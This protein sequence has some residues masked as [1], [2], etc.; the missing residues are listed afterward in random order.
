MKPVRIVSLTLVTDE[1]V[2]GLVDAT[3]IVAMSRFAADESAS[4]V[5]ETAKRIGRVADRDVEQIVA[6]NP[7]LVLS[8]RYTK[9]NAREVLSRIGVPYHELTRFETVQ[10][11]AGNIR[12]I[13]K[14]LNES[15]RG[16]VL[17][18]EMHQKLAEAGKQLPPDRRTW[19]ALYLAPGEWTAGRRTTFDELIRHTGMRNAAAESGLSGNV[20]VS[21]EQIIRIN[22]DLII[23]GT[24]YSRDAEY[25]AQLLAD[26]RL[27]TLTAIRTN[28]IVMIPSRH[29]LTTSQFIGDAA[30]HLAAAVRDTR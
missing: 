13:A 6:M 10:D 15:D 21:I 2:S 9:I 7:D 20:Q 25:S 23:I 14:V 4:N 3:R 29:L 19:Q 24:G 28:R 1:I 11:I 18:S 17:I 12:S 26:S 8:T 30:V 22:P 16:E 27:A 5:A